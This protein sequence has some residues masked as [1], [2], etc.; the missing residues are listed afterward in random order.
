M[1][2]GEIL[3]LRASKVGRR[4]QEGKCTQ[5]EK[6]KG[7]KKEDMIPA[8]ASLPDQRRSVGHSL[9]GKRGGREKPRGP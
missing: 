7:Q 5:P 6:V 2:N 9:S 8:A 1:L 3:R 4:I